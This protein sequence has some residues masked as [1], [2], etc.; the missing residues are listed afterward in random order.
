MI[1]KIICDGDPNNTRVVNAETGEEVG[2]IC[3]VKW[4]MD[5]K[6]LAVATIELYADMSLA[7]VHIDKVLI[8]AGAST[9][10]EM[11]DDGS[12]KDANREKWNKN[13]ID[14]VTRLEALLKA[15]GINHEQTIEEAK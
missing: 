7:S 2:G 8:H 11:Q 15:N 12:L 5:A 13:N 1:L 10:S 6:S 9:Y 4:Y 14:E 3:S